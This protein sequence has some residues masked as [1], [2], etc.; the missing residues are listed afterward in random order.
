MPYRVLVVENNPVTRSDDVHNLTQW[1]YEVIVPEGKGEQL[2][3][4]AKSMARQKSCDIALLDMRLLD[5]DD[6]NDET[7]LQLAKDLASIA[8]LIVTA[9]GTKKAMRRALVDL[10]VLDF[11]ERAD[12]P[13]EL[14]AALE[15]ATAKIRQRQ[16]VN[17]GKSWAVLVG[18]DH[19]T[20]TAIADLSV[21][22]N[23]VTAVQQ[24][25]SDSYEAARLLTDA[26]G[27]RFLPNRANILGELATAA[28]SA[29]ENDMFLF[30]FSGHG[31]AEAGESYLLPR[32]ARLA[33][34]KHT[35]VAMR[36][37]KEI[38]DESPAQAKVIVL[39]ACHSG[40]ALGKAEVVMTEEFIQ[41]VYAEAEGSVVLA[42]C[43]QGQ[44]SW[45]WTEQKLSVFTYYLLEAL[46]GQADY[47]N[48]GFV[49]VA[50]V[51]R[52]VTEGVKRWAEEHDKPQTPTIYASMAGEIVLVRLRQD[53]L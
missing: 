24:K 25:L 53:H 3:E 38:M 31:V 15:R 43:K 32:D 39:D 47:G 8:C 12:G 26:A 20:D 36:T 33:A 10:K 18:V 7:G 21:C 22:V 34:L 29:G 9:H 51:N 44:R 2:V 6:P 28:E 46:A 35:S 11:V 16:I 27:E 4:N 14:K 1:G 48:K 52:Y 50:D 17:P 5:E 13:R 23:D 49:T 37:I 30:Y 19:Y 40:A 45:E 41:R 42:S